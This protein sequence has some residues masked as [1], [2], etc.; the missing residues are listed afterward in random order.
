MSAQ[1]TAPTIVTPAYGGAGWS[2]TFPVLI[3][4]SAGTSNIWDGYLL[5]NSTGAVNFSSDC[6]VEFYSLSGTYYVALMNQAGT[7]WLTAYPVGQSGS[8]SNSQCTLSAAGSSVQAVTSTTLQ[9]NFAITFQ[10]AFAGLT[11]LQRPQPSAAVIGQQI[12]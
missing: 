4:D 8:D 2:Y 3:N 12:Q 11:Y 1:A 5:L 10:T 7:A 6:V 9:V